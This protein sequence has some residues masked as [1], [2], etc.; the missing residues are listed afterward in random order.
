MSTTVTAAP[1]RKAVAVGHN[2]SHLVNVSPIGL[3]T[4]TKAYGRARSP[5]F[6][7]AIDFEVLGASSRN[8]TYTKTMPTIKK[9]TDGT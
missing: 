6:A 5:A 1:N 7:R 9:V 4:K 3:I 8:P 2:M